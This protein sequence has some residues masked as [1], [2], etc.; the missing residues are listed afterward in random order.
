MNQGTGVGRD[1]RAGAAAGFADRT[2]TWLFDGL[3]RHDAWR[4]LAAGLVAEV[5][6][7]IWARMITPILIGGPLQPAAL[8]LSLFRLDP[9]YF[10]LGELIHFVT[11]FA[12]YPAAYVLMFRRILPGGVVARGAVYGVLLWVFALGICAPL[13]GLPLFLGF[14]PLAYA[15]LAGHTAFGLLLVLTYERLKT[16]RSTVQPQTA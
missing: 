1:R 14:I 8:V 11:G 9:S 12:I 6:W 3:D 16:A 5:F 15:S 10:W 7:E 4:I 13:A 2:T